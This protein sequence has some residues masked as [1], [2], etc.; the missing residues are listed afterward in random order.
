MCDERLEHPIAKI[1]GN[2]EIDDVPRVAVFDERNGT[3]LDQPPLGVTTLTTN[4]PEISKRML[5]CPPELQSL[6]V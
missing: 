1:I 4:C 5:S 3:A 2:Q 6:T